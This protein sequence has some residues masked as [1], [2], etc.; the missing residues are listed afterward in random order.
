MS[1]YI[2]RFV[3]WLMWHTRADYWLQNYE[4]G[5]QWGPFSYCCEVLPHGE[6]E[7]VKIGPFTFKHFT[8]MEVGA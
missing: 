8:P 4:H 5:L 1:K 6:Q 2:I 7:V 3:C